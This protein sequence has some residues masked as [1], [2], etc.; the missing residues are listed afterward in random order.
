MPTDPSATI[1]AAQDALLNGTTTVPTSLVTPLVALLGEADNCARMS[2]WR[3]YP[4]ATKGLAVA[5]AIL[6]ETGGV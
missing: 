2:R 5:E 4:I 3:E 6:A 1:R